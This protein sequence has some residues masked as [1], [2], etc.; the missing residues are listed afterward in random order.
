MR[1]RI[2]TEIYHTNWI[3]L[4]TDRELKVLT[5]IIERCEARRAALPPEPIDVTPTGPRPPDAHRAA[6]T[7][8]EATPARARFFRP[9]L[10]PRPGR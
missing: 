6:I 8:V 2:G 10:A 4:A 5:A 7:G 9:R 1:E 3:H